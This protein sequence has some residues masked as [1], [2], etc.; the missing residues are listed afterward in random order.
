MVLSH[1]VVRQAGL[2]TIYM[3]VY[4]PNLRII[5]FSLRISYVA[6]LSSVIQETSAHHRL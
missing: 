5:D 1:L 6:R 4:R 2:S 3:Q